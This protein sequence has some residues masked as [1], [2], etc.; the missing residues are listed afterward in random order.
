MSGCLGLGISRKVEPYFA[1]MGVSALD[2]EAEFAEE[3]DS[4]VVGKLRGEENLAESHLKRLSQ[5]ASQC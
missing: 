3:A 2:A 1:F 5:C 4:L